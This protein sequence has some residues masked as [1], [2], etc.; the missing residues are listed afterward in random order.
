MITRRSFITAFMGL[1]A[2][3]PAMAAAAAEPSATVDAFY[4]VLLSVFLW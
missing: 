4:S 3:R 2:V 1:A